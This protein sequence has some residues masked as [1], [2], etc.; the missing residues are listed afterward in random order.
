MTIPRDT[1]EFAIYAFNMRWITSRITE[2][3][4]FLTRGG[5][6]MYAMD[7]K[8]KQ[9]WLLG[10][11]RLMYAANPMSF[12]VEQAGGERKHEGPVESERIGCF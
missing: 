2:V 10:K 11:L 12:I 7:E 8:M 6:F 3:H 4:R 1:H 9:K 5:V